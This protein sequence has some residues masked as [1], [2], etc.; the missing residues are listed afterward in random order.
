MGKTRVTDLEK[1]ALEEIWRPYQSMKG[2]EKRLEKL[3]CS[4]RETFEQLATDNTGWADRVLAR[5]D[6]IGFSF[7]S[8]IVHPLVELVAAKASRLS[9]TP[10]NQP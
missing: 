1:F 8:Y 2:Y 10:E 6:A 7:P 9:P 4:L 3:P 5:T